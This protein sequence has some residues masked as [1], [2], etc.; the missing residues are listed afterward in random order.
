LWESF[1][2]SPEVDS[3]ENDNG[4]E[5]L[6]RARYISRVGVGIIAFLAAISLVGSVLL[7]LPY[8]PMTVYSY[9]PTVQRV[10]P[11]EPVPAYITYRLEEDAKVNKVEIRGDWVAKDVPGLPEGYRSKGAEGEIPGEALERGR[12]ER[13]RSS[14]VRTAPLESGEWLVAAPIDVRG[15]AYGVPHV[16][17]IE[18]LS[19]KVVRVLDPDDPECKG[20]S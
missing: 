1:A 7:L 8:S 17:Q 11:T 12:L 10:C 4:Q 20:A 16:Q 13:I 5:R 3:V 18:L 6:E 14:A 9:E 2:S 15:R 19:E